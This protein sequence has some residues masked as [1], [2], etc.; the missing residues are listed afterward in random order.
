MGEF[1]QAMQPYLTGGVYI[2][3]LEGKEHRERIKDAYTPENFDR[4]T[5]TKAKYDRDNVFGFSFNIPAAQ[6]ALEMSE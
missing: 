3:F 6:D 1:K 2:N 4:L 5:A